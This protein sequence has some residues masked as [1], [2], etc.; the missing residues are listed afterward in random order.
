MI[1]QGSADGEIHLVLT[2]E[3]HTATAGALA[4]AF[5]GTTAFERLH[6]ENLM[7]GLAREHDRGWAEVDA[8]APVDPASGLPWSV[9]ETPIPVS[10]TTGPRSIDHNERCHPYRGLLA[11]MH[12]EGLF[13][14]RQGLSAVRGIDLIDQRH[15]HLVEAMLER[16][17]ARQARLRTELA[18]DP[19]TSAWLEDDVLMR[20]YK[21]LQFFDR[22]ALWLQLDHPS[23]RRPTEIDHVPTTGPDDT[24]VRVT[25]VGHD[26]VV[27]DPYPFRVD[28]L[29][30]TIEGRWLTAQSADSDMAAALGAAATGQQ[31]VT[32]TAA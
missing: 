16:E 11:S 28:P 25:P 9:L 24:V 31:H 6:P 8:E 32:L 13:T 7:V 26:R 12:I 20:N 21:A 14:G 19:A 18:A 1:V 17:A 3:Q 30:V 15:R 2:M 27:L 29:G 22:L 4:D 10:I 23:R 5:G